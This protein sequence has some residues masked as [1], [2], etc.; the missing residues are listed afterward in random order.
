M[1][2]KRALLLVSGQLSI[3]VVL[4][5]IAVILAK[6]WKLSHYAEQ[7]WKLV[8][9]SGSVETIRSLALSLEEYIIA[10]PVAALLRF[11]ALYIFLQAFAIPGTSV[12]NILAG[13]YSG[14]LYKNYYNTALTPMPRYALIPVQFLASLCAAVGSSCCYLLSRVVGK[15]LIK[16][17]ISSNRL[18]SWQEKISQH[19]H[20]LFFYFIF[21]RVTPVI[22][23]WGANLASPHL[24][25]PLR[26]FFWGT[27]F[28]VM[29]ITWIH[30][31]LGT[32]LEELKNESGADMTLSQY[33]W[34][35][36]NMA[37]LAS[38]AGLM[39]LPPI[40]SWVMTK[41]KVK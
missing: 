27:I 34:N 18:R 29:P 25:V 16:T 13:Y 35:T 14:V 26:V 7:L 8:A 12:L 19:S 21:M 11:C 20:N 23:N 17:L 37:I 28:G 31:Q 41:R 2:H 10:S 1:L 32:R 15:P 9:S 5:F 36:Q 22:P 4:L 6:R 3:A 33:I 40:L 24:G 39:L 30:L 38:V